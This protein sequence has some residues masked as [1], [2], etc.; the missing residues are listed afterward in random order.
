MLNHIGRSDI[1]F[2]TLDTLR[3]DV[4]QALFHSGRLPNLAGCLSDQGWERRHSPATFTYAAHHAFF[5]GFLPTPMTPGVHPRLFASEFGG[6]ETTAE[7]TFVFPEATL[8]Q[9]LSRIGYHTLCVGGTG[10]FNPENS[11]GRVL[12]GLF[13]ESHWSKSMSVVDRDSA[14]HQVDCAV[15]AIQLQKERRVFC[16]INFSAIHQPNWF[17]ASDISPVDGRD[18]IDSHGA[19]LIEIDR[20]LPRLL[21]CFRE[22]GSLFA[23]ICSDH[24]T[25]YGEAG[26]WG[27]RIAHPVVWEVPYADFQW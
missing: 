7:Q 11:L 20:Q 27:H 3:Y 14:L 25:A 26:Y 19:A 23:I 12:P 22:R 10:F 21:N 17:Y 5:A 1:L 18:T 9:A 4:A 6:S 15:T 13:N 24:G 8:P 16:F 2:V